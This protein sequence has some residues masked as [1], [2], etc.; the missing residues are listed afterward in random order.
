MYFH[1]RGQPCT[2]WAAGSQFLLVMH[3]VL[4]FQPVSQPYKNQCCLCLDFRQ[5]AF[6]A[7]TETSRVQTQF[8]SSAIPPDS[9]HLTPLPWVVFNSLTAD[10]LTWNTSD[11]FLNN[12]WSEPIKMS[13]HVFRLLQMFPEVSA[14]WKVKENVL[15]VGCKCW[16]LVYC[17]DNPLQFL[18]MFIAS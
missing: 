18:S 11:L 6:G 1:H 9:K 13:H 15:T 14:S 2:L 5:E 3:T 17:F 8:M 10:L 4:W 7:T 12:R 16:F